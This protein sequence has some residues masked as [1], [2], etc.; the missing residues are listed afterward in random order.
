MR[1]AII[2]ASGLLIFMGLFI[3]AR[4]FVLHYPRAIEITTYC[5]VGFWFIATSFNM[6]VGVS[7]AGY[8]VREELP[9]MLVLF[10]VPSII[11]LLIKWKFAGNI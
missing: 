9:I 7:H 1:T 11:A 6:W 5:F 10:T 4:L 3:Y 8:S 2:L